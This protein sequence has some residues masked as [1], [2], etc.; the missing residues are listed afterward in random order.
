MSSSK[1]YEYENYLKIEREYSDN[2]IK[3]YVRELT[4]LEEFTKCDFLLI[5]K[6]KLDLFLKWAQDNYAR[7]TYVHLI[8]TYKSYNKFLKE[9]YNK[10]NYNIERLQTQ[11]VEKKIPKYLTGE[12]VKLL[13][14]SLDD[15]DK[16]SMRNK[17]LLETLYSTGMRVSEIINIKLHD[18]N[19]ENKMIKVYGKGKKERYVFLN[20]KATQVLQKYI[21]DGKV[22]R[23]ML[24]NT[25]SDYLF[26]NN[27][28]N[29]LSRQGVTFILQTCAKKVGI[30]ELTPHIIRHSIATHMLN[31]GADLRM[32][33]MLL[34][35][36]N[37]STTEIY[38]H[39]SKE[40]IQAEYNK[41]N[42]LNKRS[43]KDE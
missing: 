5:D 30:L 22:G 38:T 42:L 40:Q 39:V 13:L 19:I 34:G 29:K 3:S 1:I 4:K 11:K 33:Q 10:A 23:V 31:N 16:L 2:T 24:L 15:S 18:V 28:G 41:H 14:N 12:E 9:H 27:H 35:H 25:L 20:E 6:E 37:I 7:N 32:I 8:S 21:Y 26:L 17:A 43:R 36:E